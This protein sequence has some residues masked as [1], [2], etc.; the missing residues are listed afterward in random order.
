MRQT[1]FWFMLVVLSLPVFVLAEE[2]AAP[3]TSAKETTASAPAKASPSFKSFKD[4]YSAGNQ[5]LKD[6]K[7]DE[8]VG[9]YGAAETLATS[10]KA[11]SQAANAQG[12]ALIKARK[13]QDAKT[14]LSRAVEEDGDNKVALKNLGFVYYRL[15]DYGFGGVEELKLA[16]K[17]LEASGENPE[18]LE[19][20]KGDLSREDAY[21]KATP[22]PEPSLAGMNFKELTALADKEQAEGH[23]D[24]AM[25]ALKQAEAGAR[26]PKSKAAAENRQGKLLLDS[27]KPAEALPYF[28][29][30][31]K[32]QPDEKVYI[33]SLGLCYWVIYDSGKGKGD[34]L[35]KAVDAFYKANSIDSSYHA[36]NMKMALDELKEVNPEAAKAYAAKEDKDEAASGDEKEAGSKDGKDD[37]SK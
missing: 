29:A 21:A 32:D 30:A 20:A 6:R 16:V 35:N 26:S 19:R 15:Y 3:A 23:V 9:D 11:K 24:L 10:G 27:H 36:E 37:D 7:F 28:E 12:W 22:M 25:K 33:N 17:N 2:K 34:E 4:A 14:A 8:A 31:V 1:R 13:L 5:A 18:Q